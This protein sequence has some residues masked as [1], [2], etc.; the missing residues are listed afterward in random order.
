MNAEKA[1]Q[2]IDDYL[3]E[4]N[5]IAKEWV[6]L[7][8]LCRQALVINELQ[9]KKIVNSKIKSKRQNE[10]LL[11]MVD[12]EREKV[13]GYEQIAKV[14]SAYISILLRKLGAT[15]DDM[16]TIQSSEVREA[17]KK[18]EA[19]AMPAEASWSLYCEVIEE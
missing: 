16:I 4:P 5:N 12:E 17:I 8:N 13:V 7:L 11:R 15:K 9:A 3:L 2:M 1:I 6:E 14:H 19:R 10:R 18:Y